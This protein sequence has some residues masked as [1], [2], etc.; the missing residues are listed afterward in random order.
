MTAP[1]FADVGQEEGPLIFLIAG[2]PSGDLLG[3]RLMTALREETGGRVRF[4]GIGG[5]AMTAAGLKSRF[6]IH[7]LAVMG[8]IEVLPHLFTILKRMRETVAAVKELRPDAVVTI[9]SPSF[10]LEIA[11]RLKGQ[12]IPL[13][14]YVAPQVWAWKAWRAKS[15]ARYLDHLLALLPFEPPYFERHDLP[16]HFVGHPAVETRSAAQTG[17]A[18][19]SPCLAVLPGSR[20]GEV[21]KLLPV[22]AEVVRALAARH[23]EL[24][25]VIPTV[26]T[27]A[28]VV[29]AQVRDWPLPVTVVRGAEA[30]EKAFREATAA[31]AASGTVALELGV[32]GVPTVVAYRFAGIVGL[33]PPSLLRV[34]FVSLVNL[35]AGREVQPEFLQRRCR[36][37]EILPAVERL[38]SDP[39]ARAAQ[40][41][42]CR[43]VVEALTPPEGNPSRAA[44]RRI[45]AC[46][47]KQPS[48]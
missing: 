37:A 14:H 30:K 4:A 5:E 33:L 7:E 15:V 3:A 20:K 25:V 22:F 6:P 2:E 42:G 12:G 38:L 1:E 29:Q 24:K 43:G 9:D 13:I 10:T 17:A 44:A 11:E 18:A 39:E 47:K 23:P 26:E 8:L 28:E 41:E 16:T 45:L 40:R 31:L 21:A 48:S 27:V 46:L 19:Q 35:I 32:A 34:P 36:A